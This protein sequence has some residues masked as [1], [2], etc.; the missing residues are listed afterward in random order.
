MKMEI[1][2][3]FICSQDRTFLC[4]PFDGAFMDKTGTPVSS[5][6]TGA[7]VYIAAFYVEKETRRPFYSHITTSKEREPLNDCDNISADYFDATVD[8]ILGTGIIPR[9]DMLR[10]VPKGLEVAGKIEGYFISTGRLFHD[11]YEVTE[12]EF[13]RIITKHYSLNVKLGKTEIWFTDN[14]LNNIWWR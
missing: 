1:G 6:I 7:A 14:S 9:A 11:F 10:Y 5:S 4:K 3:P 13:R 12:D 8:P 2:T